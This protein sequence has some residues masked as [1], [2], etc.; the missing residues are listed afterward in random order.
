MQE[1][2]T[3]IILAAG[4]SRRMG[5]LTDDTPKSLLPCHGQP[6]LN[7]LIFQLR[8]SGVARVVLVVGYLKEK[9]IAS[10]RGIPGVTVEI[11]VNERYAEDVN[12]HSMELA[13]AAVREPLAIF[14]AD[15]VMED[16]LVAYVTG[17]D[18][19]GRSVWFTRGAFHPPQYGGIL[20]SDRFGNITDIRIVPE[21]RGEYAGYSKLT[22]IMRVSAKE[23]PRFREL[24]SAYAQRT[25]QQY[26]LIPWI[27]HLAELPCIEG[28]AEHYLFETFNTAGEY[29][30]I[31]E[32]NF[33]QQGPAAGDIT[34]A[35]VR[36][37]KHIEGFDEARVQQL[38]QKILHEQQ[39]T[40]PLSVEK[41]HNLVLD[42]QHRLQAAL[43]LG[44]SHVPVQGFNYEDVKVWTLRKEEPVSVPLVIARAARGEHYPYKTVK[45]KFPSAVGECAIPLEQLKGK[46]VRKGLS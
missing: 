21:Y 29:A 11:I 35:D 5:A 30:L 37:L 10:V 39:W 44:L 20:A 8:K 23:L 6:L 33:D 19:E 7:R 17:A 3:A 41:N 34:L 14:E 22:G 4:S 24:V 28:N 18:F 2:K 1:I 38:M 12:I 15:M 43:R 25:F 45:H 13:L 40:R 16:A 9:L 42:G 36:K 46:D 32:R 26:Y 31:A 27:E